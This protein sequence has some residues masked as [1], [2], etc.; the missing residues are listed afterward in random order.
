MQR[1]KITT[2]KRNLLQQKCQFPTQYIIWCQTVIKESANLLFGFFKFLENEWLNY[3]IVTIYFV[4]LIMM[5]QCYPKH[6]FQISHRLPECVQSAIVH[7]ACDAV[8]IGS[9]KCNW[10][11]AGRGELDKWPFRS[12]LPTSSVAG[13]SRSP[14]LSVPPPVLFTRRSRA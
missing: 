14:S 13:R 5:Q 2:T 12:H 4:L 9:M 10:S 7:I 11:G 8:T 1:F 3:C 6:K